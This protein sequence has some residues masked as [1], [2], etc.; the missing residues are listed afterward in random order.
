M[1]L[2]EEKFLAALGPIQWLWLLMFIITMIAIPPANAQVSRATV[3]V[4]RMSCPFCAFGVA[5]F[6][7][8]KLEIT[9]PASRRTRKV[10]GLGD[11]KFFARYTAWQWD[12]PGRTFR[13]APFMG[14]EVPTGKDDETDAVGRLPQPLQLGSGSWD[15]FLGIVLTRQTLD[16]EFD[17]SISYQL[18]TQANDFQFGDVAR[19]DLSYQYR[20]WPRKLSS[21]VP[22]FFYGVLESNLIWQDKNELVGY[23]FHKITAILISLLL[24]LFIENS[25]SASQVPEYQFIRTWGVYGESRGAFREPVGIAIAGQFNYPTD[26]ALLQKE[27]LIVADAYND[28]IQVFS[29][30]GAFLRKWGGLLALNIS[31]SAHGWFNVATAVAIS[32]KG[33]IFVADFY[34]HRIQ[35]FTPKGKF[36]LSFG[37]KGKDPGQFDRPTD[38][39]IDSDGNVYVVDFGNNRIQEFAAIK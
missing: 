33:N 6:L 17:A 7:N 27:T 24:L 28:R 35:K 9:T 39:A 36:L 1:K 13:I 29:K 14:I 23:N 21:G 38:V 15:P 22:G 37:S 20:V 4:D 12:K 19:L 3:A 32:H 16:W 8:K 10:D 18:N 5:P 26:V 11:M 25:F 31:G 30:D 34:N 2:L